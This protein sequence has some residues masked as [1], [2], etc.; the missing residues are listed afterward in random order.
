MVRMNFQIRWWRETEKLSSHPE[1]CEI[2]CVPHEKTRIEISI[3]FLKSYPADAVQA[4]HPFP[5]SHGWMTVAT[6]SDFQ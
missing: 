6:A 3:R 4:D 2:G 5:F 1:H